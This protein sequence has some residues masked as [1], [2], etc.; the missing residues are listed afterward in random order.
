MKVSTEKADSQKLVLTIEAPADEFAKSVKVA[1]KQLANR[2]N[3]PGFRKGHAPKQ[4]LVQNLGRQAILDEA[5][6]LLAPKTLNDAFI[7]EK[8]EPVDRPQIEIVTLEE[9]SNVVFKATVTPKPEVTL[10]EYK[11]IAI[12]LPKAEVAEEEIEEQIKNMRSH[13]AKMIDAQEDA[14]VEKDNFIT[15]DF[16]GKVDGTAFEGGEAK[17]YPLQVGSGQF[18]PGFEEQL[19]GVKIGEEKDVTVKFPDDYHEASLAGKDAVFSCKVN[20]IKIQ[21]LPELDDE[22]VKKSTS[23]KD[24]EDL[25]KNL[26]ENLL[27][28]AQ[29]RAEGELRNQALKK[30]SDNAKV[31]IPDV[32]IDN[33]VD[34]ML[35]ELS[36]SLESHSMNMEQYLKYSNTDMAKLRETYRQSAVDAVK[37]DLVLE[38]V[39]Q[40][41]ELKVNTEEVDAEIAAM[42]VRYGTT[43]KEV[44]KIVAKNGYVANLY[45]TIG[46]KKAAQLIID[47]LAK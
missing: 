15:L 27:K 6:E 13:H 7:E 32:M 21:E 14:V 4:I 26:H 40:A 28:A 31:D 25:K 2:V 36:A 5:F 1:C 11:G 18:I 44:R 42:A 30:A 16:L 10:G 47:N 12:E 23:Y 8:I 46:R 24:L 34:N 29:T 38:K 43:P 41:E 22:F 9:G 35:N 33:R 20:S 45:E 3:I 17:D 19:I 39:A 37:T